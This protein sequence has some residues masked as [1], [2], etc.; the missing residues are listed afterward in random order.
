M[1]CRQLAQRLTLSGERL[2]AVVIDSTE[3][4]ALRAN[5]TNQ[6]GSG[7]HQGPERLKFLLECLDVLSAERF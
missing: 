7:F 4:I 3:Y 6:I 1:Q 2:H 5:E